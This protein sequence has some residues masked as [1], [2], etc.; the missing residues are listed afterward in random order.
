MLANLS[1][2]CYHIAMKSFRVPKVNNKFALG[3]LLVLV[4]FAII[5]IFSNKDTSGTTDKAE[6]RLNT[7]QNIHFDQDTLTL[8]WSAVKNADEYNAFVTF[9]SGSANAMQYNQRT[10]DLSVQIENWVFINKTGTFFFGVRA[11]AAN[12]YRESNE[13]SAPQTIIN[14]VSSLDAPEEVDFDRETGRLAWVAVENAETYTI[15]ARTP[16]D[17]LTITGVE[18]NF[19]DFGNTLDGVTPISFTVSAHSTNIKFT[20]SNN[21]RHISYL[22]YDTVENIAVVYNPED[23]GEFQFTWDYVDQT[24]TA[25][26]YH[27]WFEYTFSNGTRTE[28]FPATPYIYTWLGYTSYIDP[29][30]LPLLNF[31]KPVPAGYFA[32]AVTINV[33][34]THAEDAPLRYTDSEPVKFT[35]TL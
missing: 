12:G 32:V 20:A 30:E 6:I 26:A 13:G 18:N 7:P 3:V 23:N 31:I 34:V 33:I 2:I 29:D 25:Y 8:S 28:I 9:G 1:R 16:T 5:G 22:Q 17:D 21:G 24:D 10:R 35:L 14:I 4:C 27:Y 11:M 19:Y 15:R